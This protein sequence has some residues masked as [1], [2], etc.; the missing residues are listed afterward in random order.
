MRRLTA[1]QVLL[2]SGGPAGNA[3][4]DD[5]QEIVVG[6][7]LRRGI[8][9]GVFGDLRTPLHTEQSSGSGAQQVR[10]VAGIARVQGEMKAPAELEEEGK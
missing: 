10:R 8:M 1:A 6:V 4:G 9:D 7:G 5:A 2:R 3:G